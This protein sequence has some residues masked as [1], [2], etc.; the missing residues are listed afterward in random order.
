MWGWPLA[1]W[2]NVAFWT[3]VAGSILAAAAVAL[4]GF[5]SFISLK[6]AGITQSIA[7][8]K[9]AAATARGEAARADAAKAISET[10]RLAVQAE[11]ARLE[12]AKANARAAEAQLELEKFKA[13]RVISEER[14]RQLAEQLKP[15]ARTKFDASVA[16]GDAEAI[17]FLTIICALLETAG[18]NWIDWNPPGGPFSMVYTITGASKPNIGQLGFFDVAIYVNPDHTPTLL[19]PAEALS[20]LLKSEG[21]ATSLEIQTHPNQVNTDAIHIAVGKKR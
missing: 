9:I 6:T 7:D 20:N 4:T 15:Y 14:V 21:F 17:V 2:D 16:P 13:P 10:A 19:H 12:I 11:E 3:L 8:E 5:S 1:V 18:W